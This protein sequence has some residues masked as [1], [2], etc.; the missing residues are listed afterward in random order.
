MTLPYILSFRSLNW[1]MKYRKK[2]DYIITLL[3]FP[4]LICR[5]GAN[6][7][8]V[9]PLSAKILK[10]QD[11]CAEMGR[12]T[13]L[14]RSVSAKILEMQDKHAEMGRTTYLVRPLSA[15]ILKRQDKH[16]EMGRMTYSFAL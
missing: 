13:Y 14:V 5:D 3:S 15:K 16:A 11:K 9:R 12:T 10:M 2:S 6:D 1:D 7:V 4:E 8:L